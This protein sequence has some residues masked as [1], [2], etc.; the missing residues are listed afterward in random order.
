MGL[1]ACPQAFSPME[2]VLERLGPMLPLTC[3]KR[4]LTTTPGSRRKRARSGGDDTSAS[5]MQQEPAARV[6]LVPGECPALAL[7]AADTGHEGTEDSRD[8]PVEGLTAA[9]AAATPAVRAL[10]AIAA[11]WGTAEPCHA[12]LAAYLG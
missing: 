12:R 9:P 3:A 11:Q 2:G 8:S 10:K 7:A 1:H 5:P 6:R 4:L